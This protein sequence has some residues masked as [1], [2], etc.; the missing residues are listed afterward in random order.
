M[1]EKVERGRKHEPVENTNAILMRPLK[2]F[3]LFYFME[4]PHST[5]LYTFSP[6]MKSEL[7]EKAN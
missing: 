1:G 3:F 7:I 4:T 2:Q 5:F 6:K